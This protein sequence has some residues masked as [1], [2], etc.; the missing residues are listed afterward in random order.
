MFPAL[1]KVAKIVAT[2]PC[3]S[4]QT[5][6][7]ANRISQQLHPRFQLASSATTSQVYL[8]SQPHAQIFLT[9][10]I[11]EFLKLSRASQD[12]VTQHGGEGQVIWGP[13]V[14]G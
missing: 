14:G 4:L 8:W 12:H 7:K 1:R 9:G 6:K 11:T 13:W 10:I 5:K 2:T 3:R